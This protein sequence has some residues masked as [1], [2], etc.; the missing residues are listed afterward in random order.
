MYLCTQRSVILKKI[1]KMYTA[2]T[3]VPYMEH[4]IEILFLYNLADNFCNYEHCIL[5]AYKHLRCEVLKFKC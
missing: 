4:K 1:K 5:R 3:S 2:F